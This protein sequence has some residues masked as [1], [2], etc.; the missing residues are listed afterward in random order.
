[1]QEWEE[2]F[3]VWFEQIN[4]ERM[5]DFWPLE[6]LLSSIL[7]WKEIVP[8]S[9]LKPF[10]VPY[11]LAAV[12]ECEFGDVCQNDIK[13]SGGTSPAWGLRL[14][15]WTGALGTALNASY[16]AIAR[17]ITTNAAFRWGAG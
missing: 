15:R 6:A 12:I 3:K 8:A 2:D 14:M 9:P 10:Y 5:D 11:C 16:A 17:M 1:M 7:D 4:E 13:F